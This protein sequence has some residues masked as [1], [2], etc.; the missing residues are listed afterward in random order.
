[1]ALTISGMNIA[2][3]EQVP[4]EESRSLLN[5]AITHFNEMGERR[6]ITFAFAQLGNMA[7]LQGRYQQAHQHFRQ[8]YQ[9]RH[10]I[11]D[12]IGLGYIYESLG[13]WALYTGRYDDAEAYLEQSLEAHQNVGNRLNALNPNKLGIV[14]RLKGNLDK[15][16]AYHQQAL[17]FARQANVK[18]NIGESLDGL[19]CVAYEQGD[20]AQAAQYWQES[21]A[22][23]QDQTDPRPDRFDLALSGP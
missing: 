3:R 20:Y 18:L 21:L 5:Q 7:L 11:R 14:A 8:G 10:E 22:I 6:I 1:M 4:S 12:Q 19:G 23:W 16:K 13:D 9:I 17:A 15:A 2:N